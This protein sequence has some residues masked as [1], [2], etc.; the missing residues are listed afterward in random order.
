MKKIFLFITISTNILFAN[1]LNSLL[2]QYQNTSEK[3][4]QTVDEKLGHVVVYS[5]KEIRLMQYKTL[6]DILK[7]LP[8]INL[9]K[10]RYG[11]D[12]PG[13][14]GTKTT[15]SGFFRFFINDYE[16]SSVHT[17][18]AT[19]TWGS[20]SLDFIDHVEVYY[21]DSSF[22]LGNETGVYFI[23]MY[24]KSAKKENATELNTS[25][26]KNEN[27]QS[28]THS[29]NF[30]N[31][32]SYLF[33]AN[34]SNENRTVD[35]ENKSFKNNADKNFLYLDISNDTTDINIGYANVKA[36]TFLGLSSDAESNDGE[37][38]S[39]DF[40][41]NL[42]KYF[43]EDKSLK[44]SV[45]LDLNYRKYE[46]TND[47]GLLV[48][49]LV[50]FSNLTNT[51]P[52]YYKEDILFTKLNAHISKTFTHKNNQFVTAFNAKNKKYKVRDRESINS[53]NEKKSYGFLNTF[54]Q[55]TIYSLLFQNNY[56]ADEN[57]Y[58]ILNAKAEKY[59]RNGYLENLNETLFRVGTI[60]TPFKNF[61]LKSFYTQTY[62]PPTFYNIDLVNKSNKDLKSQKYSIFTLEGAYTTAKSKFTLVYDNVKINDFIYFTPVGFINVD[63]EIQTESVIFNYNYILNANHTLDF[64][65]YTTKLSED[66]NSS[67]K[68]GTLKF[69][70][71][72]ENFEYFTSLIY[73][74]SYKYENVYVQDSFDFSLGTTYNYSQDVSLSIKAENIL[75]KSAE[76]LY[77]EG[78]SSKYFTLDNN[79]RKIT[80][81]V[82]WVF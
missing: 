52:I 13:L 46:E 49:P 47:E 70:G 81:S 38:N 29:Q 23:R 67:N 58:F 43:L 17:Q 69:M 57:L 16:V 44:A 51:M 64:N 42:N 12:T 28:I 82:R 72:F 24:T 76:S 74:N 75:D 20:I 25:F 31:D 4:L 11:F 66:L 18:S 61:G 19:L 80:L 77:S 68:G 79:E 36:D 60:Y 71:S 65:Y 32:W 39:K 21:G 30:K 8:L 7:E 27:S 56:Q 34:N 53:S 35:Y 10:N 48:I 45:S 1:P 6:N 22:G 2:D 40:F 5:Q 37:I 62:I 54:D 50:D 55:E 9:N 63:H 78:L 26:S 15:V 59:I 14:S 73:R 41:I 3:S 33:F